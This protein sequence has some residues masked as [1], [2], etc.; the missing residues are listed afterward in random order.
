MSPFGGTPTRGSDMTSE[1]WEAMGRFF[2]NGSLPEL[3]QAYGS[4]D[5]VVLA[6]IERARV[7]V[8]GLPAQDWALRVTLAIAAT[9]PSGGW[10]I[11][12]PTRWSAAS[13][14]S[15][16]RRSPADRRRRLASGRAGSSAD[17]P[18]SRNR[19]MLHT[20]DHVIRPATR[21]DLPELSVII[22]AASQTYRGLVPARPLDLHLASSADIAEQY[23]RPKSS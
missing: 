21:A 20:G 13:A 5:M 16:R 22:A 23:G 8:G 19:P 18:R 17:C 12:T 15:R 14:W 9:G 3:V 2:R 11:G 7:E 10:R 6:V 4:A 1:A